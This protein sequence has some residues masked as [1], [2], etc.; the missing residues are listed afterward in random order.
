MG[1]RSFGKGTVQSII[2][3][4]DGKRLLKLT[5]AEYQRPR[6]EGRAGWCVVPDPGGEIDVPAQR[7]EATIAWRRQRDLPSGGAEAAA[8]S[9]G[10]LPRHRDAVIA[11]A[12]AVIEEARQGPPGD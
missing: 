11:K 3:L 8:M 2:P 1:C 4:A 7:R 12:V 6:D 10:D 5:T 9:A